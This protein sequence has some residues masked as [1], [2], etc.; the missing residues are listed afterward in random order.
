MASSFDT[1]YGA[2]TFPGLSQAIVDGDSAAIAE[3]V[4]G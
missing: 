4:G 3:Q 2:E 1:G